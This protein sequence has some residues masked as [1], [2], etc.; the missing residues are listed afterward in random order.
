MLPLAKFFKNYIAIHFNHF[1][2]LYFLPKTPH[3]LLTNYKIKGLVG[4]Q[5][6]AYIHLSVHK[7]LQYLATNLYTAMVNFN[8]F[9]LLVEEALKTQYRST[10]GL[11]KRETCSR[12]WEFLVHSKSHPLRF[13][14]GYYLLSNQ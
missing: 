7:S 12:L 11:K 4:S 9:S 5:N 8:F 10:P 13:Q 3:L 6:D 1:I 2:V 14:S